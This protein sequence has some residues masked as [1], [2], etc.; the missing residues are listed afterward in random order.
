MNNVFFKI[1]NDDGAW[2]VEKNTETEGF[3]EKPTEGYIDDAIK[4]HFDAIS[5]NF[6][7]K[8]PQSYEFAKSTDSINR[9]FSLYD[10]SFNIYNQLRSYEIDSG[11][12]TKDIIEKWETGN[13]Q[14]PNS[15]ISNLISLYNSSKRLFNY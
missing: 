4:A 14:I 10:T 1:I 6:I 8:N 3:F 2:K 7:V 11:V 12:K 5:Q 13:Y 15:E 9:A